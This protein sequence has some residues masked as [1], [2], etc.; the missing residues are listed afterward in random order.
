QQ[1]AVGKTEDGCVRADAE[2][3]CRDDDERE[4]ITL[5]E[6]AHAVRNI[7]QNIFEE[8]DATRI[9]TLFFRL[10]HA[11]ESFQGRTASVF[12]SHTVFD[13]LLGQSIKMKAQLFVEFLV[14]L[15]AM[16]QRAPAT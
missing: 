15:V 6:Y 16:S 5:E 1:N 12:G 14:Q 10:V 11:T 2:R 8:S 4:S 9:T 7:A 3:E 13:V